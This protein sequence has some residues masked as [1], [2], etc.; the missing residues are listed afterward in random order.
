MK[1]LI[2]SWFFPPANTIGAVRIGNATRFLLDRGH[3]VRVLAGKDLPYAQTLKIDLPAERIH[4]AKWADVNALPRIIKGMFVPRRATADPKAPSAPQPGSEVSPSIVG[5]LSDQLRNLYVHLTNFPDNRAGWFP[6]AFRTGRRML[7]TWKPDLVFASGPPFTTLL[8]G[9]RLSRRY[10]LPL[11]VELRDRW[12][13][14]P[15]YPP[16]RWRIW[17]DRLAERHIV[18]RASGITTVS[19]PWADTYRKVYA[20]PVAVVFNGYDTDLCPATPSRGSDQAEALRIVYTGGIYP[21]RRD[22][23][24][25]FQAVSSLGPDADKVRIEFFGTDPNH[26]L[27]LAAR[28]G[29]IDQVVLHPAVSHE[30]A[31]VQQ[32]NADVLLLMQWNNPKEQGNVPGKFFEYI[33]ALRPILVLGL[34][35]GVP[36]TILRERGA[37]LFSNDPQQIAGQIADWIRT[38]HDKGHIPP[39]PTEVRRGL[40]RDEQCGEL[41][42]FLLRIG[43]PEEAQTGS[44]DGGSAQAPADRPRRSGARAAETEVP[45]A[46]VNE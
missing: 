38:K 7:E 27:P 39:L 5:A 19:A 28:H 31:V 25:L 22:P 20:K 21:G 37:G 43:G 15:Y 45:K 24:P 36:A 46:G 30:D 23:T 10:D 29:A 6:Y 42:R 2:V 4:Y 9:D 11:V 3:D 32:C 35:D 44:A 14:D 41:E 8:V 34:E 1:I 17:M 12:S 18:N 26:V 16:P 13:D 40:S 33:G